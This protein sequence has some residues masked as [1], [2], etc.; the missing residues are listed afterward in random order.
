[1]VHNLNHNMV[2]YNDYRNANLL[3]LPFWQT[4]DK[5]EFQCSQ[6]HPLFARKRI[7]K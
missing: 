1:M 6:M 2:Q 7:G 5:E 3:G 4:E